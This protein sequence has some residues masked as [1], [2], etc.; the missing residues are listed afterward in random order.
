[1]Y[2]HTAVREELQT[3]SIL[4]PDDLAEAIFAQGENIFRSCMFGNVDAAEF[5][6]HC[7]THCEWFKNHAMYSYE[8]KE[9]LIPLSLYGDDVNT[10]RN[11]EVGAVSIIAWTS[12][13]GYLNKSCLRYWPI[14]VYSEHCSTE[15]SLISLCLYL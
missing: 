7:A 15:A 4:Y 12:D 14:C 13:F 2:N 3:L 10:Y 11:A 9:K 5:W 8:C 6:A 1:M